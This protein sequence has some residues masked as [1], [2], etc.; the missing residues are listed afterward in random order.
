MNHT[1]TT[2]TLAFAL[3]TSSAIAQESRGGDSLHASTEAAE[4]SGESS[5]GGVVCWIGDLWDDLVVWCIG[6]DDAGAA[7]APPKAV[8]VDG[9]IRSHR[10]IAFYLDNG[11]TIDI[12]VDSM[13]AAVSV[14]ATAGGGGAPG[15][16]GFMQAM[17]TTIQD[18]T[19]LQAVVTFGA[20]VYA[21]YEYEL[22]VSG[23]WVP[24]AAQT[25]VVTPPPGFGI[26]NDKTGLRWRPSHGLIDLA[27][28]AATQ[29]A[30]A[31]TQAIMQ[32]ASQL[33]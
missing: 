26:L 16:T 13:F 12:D 33:R 19:Q 21:T 28:G 31:T 2:L 22:C 17:T 9:A 11:L 5:G 14:V 18:D 15:S 1:I 6:P 4:P 8:C 32:A 30:A 29:S 7:A 23:Q 24:Q 20:F 25:K 3:T 27:R 10:V